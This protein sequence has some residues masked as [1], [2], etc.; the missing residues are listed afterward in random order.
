MI[1]EGRYEIKLISVESV[2]TNLI[3]RKIRIR[4]VEVI[5]INGVNR[6]CRMMTKKRGLLF[7]CNTYHGRIMEPLRS[8]TIRYSERSLTI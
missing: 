6:G 1:E 4:N 7:I 8:L 3:K 5:N 2:I